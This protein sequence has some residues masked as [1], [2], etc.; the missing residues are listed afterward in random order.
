MFLT[1]FSPLIS[2]SWLLVCIAICLAN[3]RWLWDTLI[4]KMLSETLEC[5]L[6]TSSESGCERITNGFDFWVW[7]NIWSI[8]KWVNVLGS[9]WKQ[10]STCAQYWFQSVIVSFFGCIC[11]L[12]RMEVKSIVMN[13]TE[14]RSIW[15]NLSE[16]PFSFYLYWIS[17]VFYRWIWC[18]FWW[19]NLSDFSEAKNACICISWAY[20]RFHPAS[21]RCPKVVYSSSL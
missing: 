3:L 7:Y 17:D 18:A 4:V 13:G 16:V 15:Q 11:T 14:L 2:Y 19:F 8:F 5:C 1:R 20:G 6:I 9:F 21:D 12:P 10:C